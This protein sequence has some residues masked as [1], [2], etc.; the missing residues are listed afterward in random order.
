MAA[1]AFAGTGGP[2]GAGREHKRRNDTEK[3][4]DTERCVSVSRGRSEHDVSPFPCHEPLRIASRRCRWASAGIGGD[5]P[6]DFKSTGSRSREK[7]AGCGGGWA[8]GCRVIVAGSPPVREQTMRCR[9]R[10]ERGGRYRLRSCGRNSAANG[11]TAV[12]GRRVV[13]GDRF[14][15][16]DGMSHRQNPQTGN[17]QTGNPQVRQLL[18]VADVVESAHRPTPA[19]A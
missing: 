6:V 8:R 11:A 13:D 3:D 14:T 16:P 7:S 1:V 12:G 19:A 10:G 4:R 9:R 17:P 15:F 2:G 18:K 5:P